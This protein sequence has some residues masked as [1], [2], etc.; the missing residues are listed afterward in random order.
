MVRR[1]NKLSAKVTVSARPRSAGASS[2]KATRKITIKE[3]TKHKGRK[4]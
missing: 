3:P 4:R 2:R 1:K